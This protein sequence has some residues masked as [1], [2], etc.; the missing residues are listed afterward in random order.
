MLLLDNELNNY[1]DLSYQKIS[2]EKFQIIDH[3]FQK[4]VVF[5]LKNTTTTSHLQKEKLHKEKLHEDL[6]KMNNYRYV[7]G[8]GYFLDGY[9][10][11]SITGFMEQ[12]NYHGLFEIGKTY[13]FGSYHFEI[14]SKSELF[15][16]LTSYEDESK[17][18][19]YT[20]KLNG[21]SKDTFSLEIEKALFYIGS[22]FSEDI[23]Q[24][25]REFLY[26]RVIDF[27]TVGV[28][29]ELFNYTEI[30]LNLDWGSPIVSNLSSFNQGES[31]DDYNFFAYY[32]FIETFFG[33]GNEEN[34]LI[35]L[36]ESI[37]SK[38]LLTFSKEHRLIQNNGTAKSLA[39]SLYQTRNNYI[40]H[41]LNKKR[42]F[43]P[44]FNLPV[45]ALTKWKV[46]TR[47]IAIQLLNLHCGKK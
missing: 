39:K 16:F 42:T 30:N 41:K 5:N 44:T 11:V 27:R 12:E 18:D 17:Y 8:H 13:S 33:T 3:K 25:Y 10:E 21:V 37:D 29:S 15:S 38:E 22:K 46:I 23:E 6:E 14:G 19:F 7:S 45:Q 35:M 40:H 2:G 4:E 26:P 24:E 28:T 34:E 31:S 47:E 43:D 9:S 36:V 32:R 1:S 20:L